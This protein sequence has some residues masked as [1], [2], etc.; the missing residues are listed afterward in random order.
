MGDTDDGDGDGDR[1]GDTSDTSGDGETRSARGGPDPQIE[2]LADPTGVHMQTWEGVLEEMDVLAEDRRGDGWEVLTVVAAHTDAITKD[3]KDHDRFG[4]QHIV[5][6][7]HAD[8]FVEFY[9]DEAFTE[10]LVYARD[11]E[12]FRYL[13]TELI[14]P[15]NRRSVMVA[16]RF[17][18][19]RIPGLVQ[20]A[21]EEGVLNTY[22]KRI[23][24]TIVCRFEH[25]EWEPLVTPVEP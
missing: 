4:L 17:D 10:Y 3:M 14:D 23:N 13:I 25:E 16:G 20:N 11:I 1:D 22:L 8:E 18:G 6:D 5:P 24:G 19:T 12:R 15:E 21:E 2:R 9:D 7:N